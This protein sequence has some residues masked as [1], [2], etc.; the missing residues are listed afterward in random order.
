[1][2]GI[3]LACDGIDGI[4]SGARETAGGARD[5]G[6]AGGGG[7]GFDGTGGGGGMRDPTGGPEGRTA[8]EPAA[9]G[10]AL[11]KSERAGSS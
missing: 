2:D 9:G 8:G 10:G 5:F 6:G 3:E 11:R 7:G 4:G 1:M